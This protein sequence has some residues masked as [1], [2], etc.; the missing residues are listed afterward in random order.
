MRNLKISWRRRAEG[1]AVQVGWGVRSSCS[2]GLHAGVEQALGPAAT[3]RSKWGREVGL[4]LGLP[5]AP[6]LAD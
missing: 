5:P 3:G 2:L 4:V 1:L 6:L